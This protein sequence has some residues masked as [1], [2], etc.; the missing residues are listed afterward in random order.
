M[1]VK[2]L[3]LFDIDGTLLACGRQV[4]YIFV[5][6]L[7]E[8]FGGYRRPQGYNFAGR[9]DEQIVFDLVAAAGMEC[10]EIRK[11][12]PEMKRIYFERLEKLLDPAGM[13][14]LPGV[15]PLLERL[16]ERRDVVL[17]LLTGNWRRG[18]VIKLSRFGLGR[19]FPF[20]AFGDDAAARRDLVPIALERA[21]AAAGREPFDADEV[22]IVGDSELDV[23]CANAAGVRS[24]AVATGHTSPERLRAAG[25]DWVFSDLEQATLEVELFRA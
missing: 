22:L 6:A 20:G 4:G 23:D 21:A 14:L 15:V 10:A 1:A 2:H 7:E 24:V 17:G 25:A 11:R 13:V 5:G 12:L 18:A 19:F 8:V 9:T 3:V 16:Q